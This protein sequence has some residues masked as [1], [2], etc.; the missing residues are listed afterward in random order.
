MGKDAKEYTEESVFMHRSHC[1]AHII[2]VRKRGNKNNFLSDK[3][4][5]SFKIFQQRA[6]MTEQNH[7]PSV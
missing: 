1:R 4:I 3:E 7:T 5:K 2:E 6:K